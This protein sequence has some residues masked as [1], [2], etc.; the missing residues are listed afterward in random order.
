MVRDTLARAGLYQGLG[1][2]I[3]R[4][5]EFLTTTDLASLPP[6][7]QDVDGDGVYASVSDYTT[8]PLSAG[9]WEAHRRHLDVHCVVCGSEL[10]GVAPAAR[11]AAGPYRSGDGRHLVVGL[12]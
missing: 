6:G 11:L 12:R 2:G 3:A 8:K 5:L 9:R 4:A 1:T 10:I 7:R